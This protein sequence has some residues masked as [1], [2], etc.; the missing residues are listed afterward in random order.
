MM[1]GGIWQRNEL[2]VYQGPSPL[3]H[4]LAEHPDQAL[5]T[6]PLPTREQDRGICSPGFHL[7]SQTKVPRAC[8]GS[9]PAEKH[10]CLVLVTPALLEVPDR[11][12]LLMF[13]LDMHGKSKGGA[14]KGHGRNLVLY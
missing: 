12:F 9:E 1:H 6:L 10:L 2:G 5:Q 3:F 11:K 4:L 8:V 14:R 7:L 13:L